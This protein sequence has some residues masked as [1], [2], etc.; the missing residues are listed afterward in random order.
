MSHMGGH[1]QIRSSRGA[2]TVHPTVLRRSTRI[3]FI[4]TKMIYIHLDMSEN[5]A[6]GLQSLAFPSVV[7]SITTLTRLNKTLRLA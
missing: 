7:I 4:L 5:P 3:D 2:S 1:K 6:A